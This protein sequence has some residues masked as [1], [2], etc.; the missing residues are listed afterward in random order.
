VLVA[1]VLKRFPAYVDSRYK[2]ASLTRLK[3]VRLAVAAQFVAA[4]SVRRLSAIQKRGHH[5]AV[6]S[7]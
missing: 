5:F 3:V 2:S 1:D 6:R 4:S 7:Q